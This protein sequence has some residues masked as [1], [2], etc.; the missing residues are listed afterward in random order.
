M[1]ISERWWNVSSLDKGSMNDEKQSIGVDD[2]D[3][4]CVPPKPPKNNRGR[5][6][7]E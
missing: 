7:G 1:L 4:I 3:V 2:D 5:A 6:I